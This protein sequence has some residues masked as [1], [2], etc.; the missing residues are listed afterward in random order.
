[1]TGARRVLAAA[2]VVLREAAAAEARLLVLADRD[3]P[4]GRGATA[5]LEKAGA[6][7]VQ[8][9]PPDHAGAEAILRAAPAPPGAV[10]VALTPCAREARRA[11]ALTVNPSRCNRCGA[12]LSLGCPAISDPGGEAMAVDPAV[13]TGCGR[14]APLCRARAIGR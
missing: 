11:P 1:V 2:D 13:C 6:A 3:G 7:I 4:E 9:D 12:C 14:C 5:R 8:H 10:L